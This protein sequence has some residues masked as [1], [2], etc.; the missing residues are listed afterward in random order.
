MMAH[1]NRDFRLGSQDSKVEQCDVLHARSKI[2]QICVAPDT[3]VPTYARPNY[4]DYGLQNQENV[5]PINRRRNSMFS[6]HFAH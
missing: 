1:A 2:S 6:V 3:C 4:E 5:T